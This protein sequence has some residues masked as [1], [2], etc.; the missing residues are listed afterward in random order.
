MK[1]QVISCILWLAVE[2]CRQLLHLLSATERG[3]GAACHPADLRSLQDR[4]AGARGQAGRGREEVGL[5]A[6]ELKLGQMEIGNVRNAYGSKLRMIA[7][8]FFRDF[9]VS[10]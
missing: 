4:P 9:A 3:Q 7:K 6:P 8:D 1:L 5:S 2:T 10:S